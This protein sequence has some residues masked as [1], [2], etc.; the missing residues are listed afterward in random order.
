MGI[1]TNRTRIRNEDEEEA[2]ERSGIRD[3]G[4]LKHTEKPRVMDLPSKVSPDDWRLTGNEGWLD[5]KVW[6]RKAYGAPRPDWDHDHCFWSRQR[7]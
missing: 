7:R 5:R 4:T 1:E 2:D 3:E 6:T